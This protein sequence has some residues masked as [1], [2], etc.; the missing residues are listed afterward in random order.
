MKLKTLAYLR[1]STHKKHE[2][3]KASKW[4]LLYCAFM[5]RIKGPD[6]KGLGEEAPA[7]LDFIYGKHN[8]LHC[9]IL[10]VICVYK[11]LQNISM[12]TTILIQTLYELVLHLLCV[13]IQAFT[14]R[15]TVIII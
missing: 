3:T 5:F 13:R 12:F 10:Q 4:L 15:A 11:P 7:L 1:K 14:A 2:D 8:M 6:T 9:N